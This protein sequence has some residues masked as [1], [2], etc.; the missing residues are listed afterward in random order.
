MHVNHTVVR[1]QML[2]QNN[3]NINEGWCL[4]PRDH[5]RSALHELHWLPI[6]LRIKFKLALLMFLVHTNQC[7]AFISESVTSV[8]CGPAQLRLCSSDG[9]HYT[10][11]RTR[12]K[13]DERTFS[14]DGF[15]IWNSPSTYP[16]CYHKH[17]FKRHLK[18]YYFN[19]HFIMPYAFY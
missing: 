2:R 10:T 12:T 17:C 1:D 4:P 5:V 16:F 11:P 14:V 9:T 19:I 6:L 7:A 8:S 3:L 15:S 18:T 13:F